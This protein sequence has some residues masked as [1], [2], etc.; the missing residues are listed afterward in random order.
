MNRLS[1]EI[2]GWSSRLRE[3]HGF[4]LDKEMSKAHNMLDLETTRVMTDLRYARNVRGHTCCEAPLVSSLL[5]RRSWHWS[6]PM[7]I[8]ESWLV[9]IS[10]LSPKTCNSPFH[11]QSSFCR[12]DI[13]DTYYRSIP[14]MISWS[15]SRT[16]AKTSSQMTLMCRMSIAIWWNHI[17]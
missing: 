14:I 16:W 13:I 5:R 12:L 6:V 8:I 11:T 9:I 15:I 1:W 17:L 7:T 2:T 4:I 3:N 10:I